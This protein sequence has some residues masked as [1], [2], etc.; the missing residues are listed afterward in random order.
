MVLITRSG[1]IGVAISTNHPSFD[2]TEKTYVASGF[3]ITSK[4][5]EG[6]DANT[7]ANYINLFD[8]QKYLTAMASGAC[9]KNIAQPTIANIPIPEMLLTGNVSFK[10]LFDEYE[11]ESR[12]I[13][14]EIEKHEAKLESLKLGIS[15]SINE[16][17]LNIDVE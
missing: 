15:K 16:K 12:N 11:Q 4:I 14:E 3:V 6:F 7:I 17:M 1:T 13:L 2:F 10:E 8:V 5:K 9:Q